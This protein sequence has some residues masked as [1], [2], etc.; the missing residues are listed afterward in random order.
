MGDS[1]DIN[2]HFSELMTSVRLNPSDTG[3]T[4]SFSGEDPIFESGVRLGAAYS[5]PYMGTAAAA[6]TIWR[7]RTGRSQDLKI[8]L[9]KAVHYIAD[10]P[11]SKLN[12]RLYPG[13]YFDGCNLGEDFYR[14]KDDRWFVPVGFYPHME[15]PWCDFLG[16]AP[17]KGPIAAKIAQWNALEL[18]EQCNARGLV[19]GMVRTIDEWR[20]TECGMQLAQTP[21]IEIVK[22]ADS[23]PEPFA[24][25]A[26]RRGPY[27]ICG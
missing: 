25:G 9:R 26:A 5:I 8:D 17:T 1:F 12:G 24:R 6:A 22:L 2:A 19:G 16:C 14:T 27:R 15:R 10:V 11:F 4:I 23:E 20:N 3:G 13:P 21:V 7:M 18:E